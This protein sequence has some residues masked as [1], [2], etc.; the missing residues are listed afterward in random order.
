MVNCDLSPTVAEFSIRKGA[1]GNCRQSIAA[2]VMTIGILIEETSML[3]NTCISIF[4]TCNRSP[5]ITVRNLCSSL[6]DSWTLPRTTL[7]FIVLGK[8]WVNH[9]PAYI[10]WNCRMLWGPILW[11][12]IPLCCVVVAVNEWK[13][14]L[15]TYWFAFRTKRL[16]S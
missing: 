12:F 16:R 9:L 13:I 8:R 2:T 1:S 15:C 14:V 7:F 5:V 4:L 6:V 11:L 3:P 10:W